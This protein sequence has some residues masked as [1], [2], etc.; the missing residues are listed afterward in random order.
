MQQASTEPLAPTAP[1]LAATGLRVLALGV[2]SSKKTTAAL[3]INGD[4]RRYPVNSEN[5]YADL[6]Q[7]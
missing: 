7:P 3:N 6:G 1:L 5:D 4:W 2:C